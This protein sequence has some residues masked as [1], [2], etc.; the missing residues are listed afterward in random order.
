MPAKVRG[1]LTSQFD[2][3]ARW[4][5]IQWREGKGKGKSVEGQSSEAGEAISN[6]KSTA[7]LEPEGSSKP[8][9]LR[10]DPITKKLKVRTVT[11]PSFR[12]AI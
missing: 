11:L 2:L 1:R 3:E 6:G 4:D 7:A 12:K 5:G 8:W 9:S 10:S